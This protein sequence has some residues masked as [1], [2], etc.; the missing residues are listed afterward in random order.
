[1][2]EPKDTYQIALSREELLV[3]MA[4]LNARELPGYDMKWTEEMSKE[5]LEKISEVAERALFARNFLARDKD[6]KVYVNPLVFSAVGACVIP[7]RSVILWQ[8]K[9]GKSFEQYYFH[10]SRKMN[11]IHFMPHS[12]IHQFVAVED[13]K[14]LVRSLLGVISLPTNL[15]KAPQMSFAIPFALLDETRQLA[16][17]LELNKVSELLSSYF[18]DKEGCRL[19]TDA[20][21]NP[22]SYTT[23]TQIDHKTNHAD[24][25]SILQGHDS[26]WNIKPEEEQN[27]KK[28]RI[29]STFTSE[30][31]EK[32]KTK[33]L[34]DNA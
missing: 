1:M 5:D 32:I 22:I 25:F 12:M 19:F 33:L 3:V 18:M 16:K 13:K 34:D 7:E 8:V 29:E 11:V 26:L 6:Q 27:E 2:A 23:I 28:A 17:G 24:D 10:V 21:V 20:L 30:I 4:Y 9:P 31:I 15:T 14:Q